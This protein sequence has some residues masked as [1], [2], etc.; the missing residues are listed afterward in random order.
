MYTDNIDLILSLPYELVAE[1]LTEWL[2]IEHVAHLDSAYCVWK[3]RH[4]FLKMLCWRR[5]RTFTL[6]RSRS[7]F[8]QWMISRNI[9][10]SRIVFTSTLSMAGTNETDQHSII[11]SQTVVLHGL[12]KKDALEILVVIAYHLKNISTFRVINCEVDMSFRTI[13]ERNTCLTD[14]TLY[15]CSS[16]TRLDLKGVTCPNLRSLVL[17][18]S[19][20]D[21]ETFQSMCQLASNAVS[22]RTDCTLRH[23]GGISTHFNRLRSLQLGSISMIPQL[24]LDFSRT[25]SSVTNFDL[26]GGGFSDA[27]LTAVFRHCGCIRTLS[28]SN[29]P[30]SVTNVSLKVL[31]SYHALSLQVLYIKRCRCLT[32]MDLTHLLQA[33]RSLH[34]ISIH[35][36]EHVNEEDEEDMFNMMH[37]SP[38]L[39]QAMHDHPRFDTLFIS[40]YFLS[41]ESANSLCQ[42][43][44]NLKVLNIRCPHELQRLTLVLEKCT[45]LRKVCV[46]FATPALVADWR[47]ANT[48]LNVLG[49]LRFLSVFTFNVSTYP[50]YVH[51]V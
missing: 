11:Q 6:T 19:P 40:G 44:G 9:P 45:S 42:H 49:G 36:D 27:L 16:L 35:V 21:N 50:T 37:L 4:H 34:T 20:V 29:T 26:D 3:V 12:Q 46:P 8:M 7:I 48:N 31:A 18:Y 51:E 14:L 39:M 22:F 5:R 10:A 1:I 41:E 43:G 13:L 47:D 25:F 15:R 33:C 24:H 23:W 2:K 38:A 17:V 28:L 32:S 30:R